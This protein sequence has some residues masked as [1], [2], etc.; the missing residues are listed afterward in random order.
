MTLIVLSAFLSSCATAPAPHPAVTAPIIPSDR[1]TTIHAVAPGETLWRIS[2]MYNVPVSTIIDTN[3]LKTSDL[4]MGQKLKIPGATKAQPV[5]SLYPSHKWKY[6]I[7][8]HSATR[9]GNS[10]AFNN[11]HL[12]KGWDKG[13][14]YH[15][16]IDRRASGK[17]DGQIETSPRWLKQEDGAHCKANDMNP[18]AIGICLVGD[19]DHE[20][21]TPKQMNSLVELV[22]TLK[23][24][25]KIPDKN[26][27]GHGH[28]KG[29]TTHCP[30]KKF[31]WQTFKDRIKP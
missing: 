31:P 14:G 28:V 8:H 23:E 24:Y 12:K 21:V 16:I 15:F 18:V 20:Y 17:Q 4:K 1:R 29:A 7:I 26:I 5:I 30:G 27:M 22:D 19:F 6:I 13:V 9:E 10:L 11:A 2:K 25:Y 3:H